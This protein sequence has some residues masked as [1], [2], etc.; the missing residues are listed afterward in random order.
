MFLNFGKSEPQHSYKHGSY[1]KRKSFAGS[2]LSAETKALTTDQPIDKRRDT[3]SYVGGCSGMINKQMNESLVDWLNDLWVGWLIEWRRLHCIT[4]FITWKIEIHFFYASFLCLIKSMC[5][6]F[7]ACRVNQI[8]TLTSLAIILFSDF[9]VICH[10]LCFYLH[11]S[12]FQF[13][14]KSLFLLRRVFCA[15]NVFFG[16][17]YFWRCLTS[18]IILRFVLS[19]GSWVLR[20]SGRGQQCPNWLSP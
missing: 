2:S 6:F 7:E 9:A 10:K 19:W 12:V 1:K 18:Y 16:N 14:R 4:L 20:R 8:L 13:C 3:S 15:K 5:C 17:V 11:I